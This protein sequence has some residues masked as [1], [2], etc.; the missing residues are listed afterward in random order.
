[1]DTGGVAAVKEWIRPATAQLPGEVLD[2][3]GWEETLN[4]KAAMPTYPCLI[5]ER[6]IVA[7]LYNMVNV[8]TAVWIDESGRIVR[9][10][11]PAGATDGFRTM[12]RAR[13]K[14]PAEAA[15]SGKQ[16]R[17]RYVEAIRDWVEKGDASIYALAPD[18]VRR[19][20]RGKTEQEALAAANFHLGQYL[21]QQGQR[22]AAQRYFAE[23]KRL[24]PE[25]WSFI[26]QSLE[27]EETGKAFGPEFWAEVDLLGEKLYYP[28]IDL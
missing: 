12:D 26:R 13:L 16:A 3:M 18:E 17:K 24:H 28:P 7:D 27:L 9:P 19:R 5:D 11:E 14:M 23:A 10:A 25:N 1:M 6:H 15:A 8:P 4:R 22:N 2:I 20:L 21:Y